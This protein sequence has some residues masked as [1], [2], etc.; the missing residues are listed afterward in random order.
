M[1]R[2]VGLPEAID[3][4]T[5]GKFLKAERGFSLGFIDEVVP[6]D[7]LMDT[8]LAAAQKFIKGELVTS[9]RMASRRFDRLPSASE[10]EHLFNYVKAETAKKAKGYIAPFKIIEAM[11]KGLSMD[12]EADI[13]LE[14]ELFG[15]CLVSD[16]AKNLI[17]I[18]LNERAAGRLPRIKG[19]EPAKIKKVGMLGGGVMGSSIV[20]LLLSYGFEAVLWEINQEA[21]DKALAAVK[22]TFAY[23]LKTNKLKAGQLEE[24]IA[25]KLTQTTDLAAMA[26]CDLIIEAV[27]ENMEVKKDIWKKLEGICR[28]GCGLRHQHLG[29]AH[30]RHGHR[31]GRPGPHDRPAL[32]Q[33]GRAHAPAGD[34]LRRTDLGPDPGH[35]RGLW[36]GHQEGAGGGQR[37]ARLLRKPP[38][39][40]AHGRFGVPGGRRGGPHGHRKGHALLRH[41][42]G[43]GHPGRPHGH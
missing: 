43:T 33:P 35:L 14:A 20:H 18:F 7:Q 19:I 2:L 32:L 25:T 37:R 39:G 4:I 34:H 15:D 9:T 40:R 3:M 6:A 5:T 12:F 11:E 21:L 42:H 24:L 38:A 41:A 16:V 30:Q 36:P 27:V 26:G 28:P 10:K 8:A 1:P 13:A 17:G 23:K 31:A 29:P 22:K